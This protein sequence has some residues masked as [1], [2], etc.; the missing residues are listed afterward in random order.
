MKLLDP[1]TRAFLIDI[2][3][4]SKYRKHPRAIEFVSDMIILGQYT[5]ASQDDIFRQDELFNSLDNLRRY[6]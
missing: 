6:R 5:D 2:T 1:I 3:Q 4:A